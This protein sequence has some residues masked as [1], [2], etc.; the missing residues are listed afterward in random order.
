MMRLEPGPPSSLSRQFCSAP[1]WT[2][3]CIDL[4]QRLLQLHPQLVGRAGTCCLHVLRA[5]QLCLQPA[6]VYKGLFQLLC[7][8]VQLLLQQGDVKLDLDHIVV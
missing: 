3:P 6:S 8:A 7:Q 1:A 4:C 2:I 5:P